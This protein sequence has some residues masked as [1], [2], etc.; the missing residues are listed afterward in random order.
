MGLAR[1][2]YSI[3]IAEWD[4]GWGQFSQCGSGYPSM[5]FDPQ[6]LAKKLSMVA[7][8]TNLSTKEV[9]RE[10]SQGQPS[11]TS[12]FKV[13]VRSCLKKTTRNKAGW[14]AGFLSLSTAH[15]MSGTSVQEIQHPL[16][17]SASAALTHTDTRKN[18][19]G[20]K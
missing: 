18:R 13:S 14:R 2:L 11:H 6:H 1:K 4:C 19:K 5:R 9:E 17:A 12:E 15:Q 16:L 10:G 3:A 8:V 20:Q 7:P